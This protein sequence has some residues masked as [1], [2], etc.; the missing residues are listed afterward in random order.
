MT[1]QTAPIRI[2]RPWYAWI[3]VLLQ[4]VIAVTA[5]PVGVM[6]IVQPDGNL[7]QMPV[8]W[9]EHTPFTSY[10]VPGV[11][12]LGMNGIGQLVAA[13]LIVIRHPLAPWLTGGLGVALMAWIAFQ[14]LTVE[15]MWLQPVIG[16]IGLVEGFVALFWLR[17]LGYL[18][19]AGRPSVVHGR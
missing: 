5:I 12:L 7:M 19:L 9:L 8:S 3:A 11:L 17:R 1:A 15:W 6:L 4:V 2:E 18:R 13:V 14:L 16:V 10:L